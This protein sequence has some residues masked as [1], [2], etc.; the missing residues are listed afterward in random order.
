MTDHLLIETG[1]PQTGPACERFLGDAAR[2]ARDGHA[3]VLF[4]VE[5]GVTAAVPGSAPGIETFLSDGGELWVDTFSAAQR[6]L[7]AADLTPRA[8]LVEMAD[9]AAKLLEPRV[10][11]VWH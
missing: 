5:N 4:L 9:V 8:R 1:G 3:V 7:P 11:A 10:R 6:A 2:L